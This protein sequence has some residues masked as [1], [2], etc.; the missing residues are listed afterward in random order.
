[1]TGEPRRLCL[2][3]R[4]VKGGDSPGCTSIEEALDAAL[5]APVLD[6]VLAAAPAA[7]EGLDDHA[8]SLPQQCLMSHYQKDLLQR[9]GYLDNR[10]RGIMSRRIRLTAEVLCGVAASIVEESCELRATARQLRED[11]IRLRRER[12]QQ[13]D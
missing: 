3:A 7:E 6:D 8:E 13:R 9:L 5:V 12:H 1:M 4:S 2:L 11:A 10:Q